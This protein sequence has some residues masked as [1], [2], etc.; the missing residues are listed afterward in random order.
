MY[1]R[2]KMLQNPQFY[3]SIR[4]VWNIISVL[5]K[6]GDYERDYDMERGVW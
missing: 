2:W 4:A 6:K 3:Q 1:S 5:R